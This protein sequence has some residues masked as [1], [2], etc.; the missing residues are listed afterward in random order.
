M[1]LGD[2]QLEGVDKLLEKFET[3]FSAGTRG[4]KQTHLTEYI[5]E[6]VVSTWCS[7]VIVVDKKQIPGQP[8]K[9]R[10][11]LDY[12]ALNSVTRLQRYQ[13]PLI[14]QILTSLKMSSC[15]SVLD[16]TMAYHHIP[17]RESNKVKTAFQAPGL[18]KFEYNYVS[19]GLVNATYAFQQ[20][21]TAILFNLKIQKEGNER[22][23]NAFVYLDDIITFS[24]LY[25]EHLEDLYL[26]MSRLQSANLTL[27][28]E[29]CYLFKIGVNFLGY[30]LCC[31]GVKP[32]TEKVKAIRKMGPPV[33]KSQLQT[34]LGGMNTLA[35]GNFI[36]WADFLKSNR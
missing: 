1:Q 20:L 32:Q 13:L 5:I 36:C 27:K 6:I 26:I 21:I 33:T 22:R 8:K 3:L 10:L 25:E 30:T 11:V 15:I 23:V 9:F 24:D 16:L 35:N 2:E 18:P 12:R 31:K 29:K 7:P 17:I 28:K 4:F 34:F 19:F 14:S